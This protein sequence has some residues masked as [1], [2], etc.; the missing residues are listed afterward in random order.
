MLSKLRGHAGFVTALQAMVDGLEQAGKRK[1]FMVDLNSF[2]RFSYKDP[3]GSYPVIICVGCAAVCALQQVTGINL[4]LETIIGFN[5]H[6]ERVGEREGMVYDF[7][8]A[9]DSATRKGRLGPLAD[10]CGLSTIQ[11]SKNAGWVLTNSN[12]EYSLSKVKRY[13]KQYMFEHDLEWHYQ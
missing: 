9:I 7:E 2:G 10:F 13:I 6:A 3:E 11:F 4:T 8:M 12:W 1:T 5:K